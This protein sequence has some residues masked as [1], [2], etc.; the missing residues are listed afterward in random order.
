MA[1]PK[2]ADGNR[3]PQKKGNRIVTN[4]EAA[5][6]KGKA[7]KPPTF[8]GKEDKGMGKEVCGVYASSCR[9]LITTIP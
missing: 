1:K 5:A 6:S 2:V 9:K 7:T 8:G 4:V 3:P